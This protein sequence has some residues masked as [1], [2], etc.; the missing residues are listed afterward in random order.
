MIVRT[1]AVA[2]LIALAGC[3]EVRRAFPEGARDGGADAF[4]H[5]AVCGD[6]IREGDEECDPGR[7]ADPRCQACKLLSD[8]CDD[9]NVIDL[10]SGLD[11]FGTRYAGNTDG[12]GHRHKGKCGG[13]GSDQRVHR[14]KAPVRGRL[15]VETTLGKTPFDS[16]VYVRTDCHDPA[17]EIVCSDD[18]KMGVVR[19][20]HGVGP[21]L[22]AGDVVSVFVDGYSGSDH[23]PYELVARVRPLVA[24]AG[25]CD[26]EGERD[27]CDAGLACRQIGPGFEGTCGTARAPAIAAADAIRSNADLWRIAV[28]GS[29]ED[30]DFTAVH[31]ELLD[32][33][34]AVLTFDALGDKKRVMEVAV[35]SAR[36]IAHQATF[37][38]IASL[39]GLK[40][41]TTSTQLQARLRLEDRAGLRSDEVTV[42][43]RMPT[44]AA[45]GSGC[46]GDGFGDTCDAGLACHAGACAPASAAVLSAAS[47]VELPDGRV[48]VLAQGSDPDGD[49]TLLEAT[50]L[51]GTGAPAMVL[52]ENGDGQPDSATLRRGLEVS[53]FGQ[54]S[55]V[56]THTHGALPGVAGA[57]V[58]VI[59]RAGLASADVMVARTALPL[60]GAGQAC[61]RLGLA[62]GCEPGLVCVGAEGAALCQPLAMAE[63]AACLS[64]MP[65]GSG[66][67]A[68]AIS[69]EP[70]VASLFDGACAKARGAPER[71]VTF[72][73][74]GLSDLLAWAPAGWASFDPVLYL[75]GGGADGC[76]GM[77]REVACND[78][79]ARLPD[80]GAKLEVM[81]LA[82]GAYS[83]VVDGATL[84]DGSGGG[85]RAALVALLRSHA[86]LGQAC[87]PYGLRSRCAGGRCALDGT[88]WICRAKP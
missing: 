60:G 73:T 16:V 11:G 49:V 22:A 10:E 85:G 42:P 62:S 44:P 3:G 21:I 32:G 54:T 9:T 34:G 47:L 45:V 48:R 87:D 28:R 63:E 55:F 19:V 7:A 77:A 27:E 78:D 58:H 51:D 57:L 84:G 24:A 74:R 88:R 2:V 83:L 33:T 13:D 71:V 81:D 56:A 50:L 15:V 39:H 69:T 5:K 6:G 79:E 70:R 59:D 61:D 38:A 31:V 52:D 18:V 30:G 40:D 82:A 46:D 67:G 76:S 64:A 37:R 4:V 86:A 23:G 65:L 72:Q 26:P 75:R 17:S 14:F 35:P 20:S 8:P 66:L 25:A 41:L 68:L 29:D 36:P 43:I 80:L 12:L 53:V 1:G